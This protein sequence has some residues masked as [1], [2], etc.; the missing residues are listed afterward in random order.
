[1]QRITFAGESSAPASARSSRAIW[2]R[3]RARRREF[4]G[5]QGKQR[6]EKEG[7]Q[8]A[9]WLLALA[10]RGRSASCTG[11]ARR[12]QLGASRR[13][14]GERR[15]RHGEERRRLGPCAAEKLQQRPRQREM[16]R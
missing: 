15:A 8:A 11:G 9:A 1:M 10:G 2:S 4:H 7:E 3:S 5:E 6:R 12:E 16:K 14:S 13:R